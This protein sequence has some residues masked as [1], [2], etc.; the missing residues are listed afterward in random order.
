MR[1]QGVTKDLWDDEENHNRK[2]VDMVKVAKI[3]YA[4]IA[5]VFMAV[6]WVVVISGMES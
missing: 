6:Y 3:L 1:G 4:A 5:V 2:R